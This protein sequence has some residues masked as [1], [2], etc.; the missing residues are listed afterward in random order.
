MKKEN[1][2]KWWDVIEAQKE[3]K[4]IQSRRCDEKEWKDCVNP[5]YLDDYE[6]RAKPE[7]E[8]VPFDFSDA[9]KLIGK[10]VRNKHIQEIKM[11][12]GLTDT[13]IVLSRQW[14]HF[15]SVLDDYTFLDGSP[16]G[17]R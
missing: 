2:I 9:E 10:I 16:C 5:S 17:K 13:G 7:P 4:Q 14:Y 3:G 8:Y 1:L 15:Q 11:I 12:V 6:Y